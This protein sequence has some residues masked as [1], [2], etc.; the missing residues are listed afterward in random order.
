MT[1]RKFSKSLTETID[2]Q[3]KNIFGEMATSAIYKY[4][5][6]SHSLKQDNIHE[7]LDVFSDG[8]TE[9]L[10][11]GARVVEKVILEDLY[12]NFGQEF[13]FKEGYK[14]TDYID[15]LKTR[16]KTLKRQ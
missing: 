4:L 3:L 2:S 16:T 1:E 5:E 6:S 15:E 11:S 9:F 10:S 14:F 13:N 8:L 7:K 12:C